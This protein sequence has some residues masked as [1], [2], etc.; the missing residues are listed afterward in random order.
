[1]ARY[2][3]QQ[4]QYIQL[5]HI[6]KSQLHVADDTH[7]ANCLHFSQGRTESTKQMERLELDA[8]LD[9]LK[10]IG[11]KPTSKKRN[12]KRNTGSFSP[13]GRGTVHDKLRSVWFEMCD[14]GFVHA[15]SEE[16][17]F[18]Y[19]WNQL[20][21]NWPEKLATPRTLNNIP[22]KCIHP[23]VNRLKRW[24]KRCITEAN[25]V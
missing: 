12:S 3:K 10:K 6:A 1:M 13:V 18:N 21:A 4:A 11:F 20:K 5:I 2:L 14:A 24:Q 8:Y 9:H 17:I 19:A 22:A 23:I 16:A 15:R 25:N 7:R